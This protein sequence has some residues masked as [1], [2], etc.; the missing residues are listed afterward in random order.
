MPRKSVIDPIDELE[1]GLAGRGIDCVRE[2]FRVPSFPQI[3]PSAGYLCGAAGAFLLAAG[4]PVPS[5]FSGLAGALLLLVDAC[6]FSP[7][8]WLGPK[9]PRSALVLPG[10][11]SERSRKALFLAVPL[12]CRLTAMGYFSGEAAFRRAVAS[13]GLLLSLA[14]PVLAGAATLL[15]LQTSPA[16]GML[17]GS[18]LAA[19]AAGAW[20][21]EK[22]NLA[23][24]NMAAD[25]VERWVPE[26]GAEFRPF[27]F[28]YSGDAA[29]VK[30]F[31]AKY[32]HPLF[33]GHGIFIEFA[34][35]ARG[36]VAASEREGGFFLPYRVEPALLSRVREAAKACGFPAPHARVL[37]F[38]SGGLAAMARGF[39]AV[40]LFRLEIPTPEGADL[41]RETVIAWVREIVRRSG[42]PAGSQAAGPDK[43]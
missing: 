32:R 3:S 14:V 25:W 5:F 9:E 4:C 31:L 19:L 35:G 23:E 34:E 13:F 38:P 40:T 12:R 17:A 7:L 30:F 6:G 18:A 16:A 42:A 22:S 41:P 27:L 39:K 28:V 10:T 11:F 15:Y 29:E 20:I 36:P 26:D 2:R 37:R 21:P 8:D 33:R 43:S 1:K 24:R